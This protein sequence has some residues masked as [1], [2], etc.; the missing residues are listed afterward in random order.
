M[1]LDGCCER[2]FNRPWIMAFPLMLVTAAQD[3]TEPRSIYLAPCSRRSFASSS[4]FLYINYLYAT[5]LRGLSPF[6]TIRL[7]F[8]LLL[9]LFC[10]V[11][12]RR[13]RRTRR[14]LSLLFSSHKYIP[15]D[16]GSEKCCGKEK[17]KL[18]VL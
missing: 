1:G 18:T 3:G 14:F 6:N 7:L 10:F 17:E 15:H 11:F 16:P 5:A 2:D 8:L 9:L 13:R 4:F 12:L